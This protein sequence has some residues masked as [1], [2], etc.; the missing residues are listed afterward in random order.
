MTALRRPIIP[1]LAV[2]LAV[3]ATA[4]A[5]RPVAPA[6]PAPKEVVAA[7][8]PSPVEQ[9]SRRSLSVFESGCWYFCQ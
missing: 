6:R 5:K 2:V 3:M 1:V 8:T 7:I 9:N 4:C